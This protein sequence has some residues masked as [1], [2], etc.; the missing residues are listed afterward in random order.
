MKK[1]IFVLIALCGILALSGCQKSQTP[2]SQTS[3][4]E[5]DIELGSN[6]TKPQATQ[7][8]APVETPATDGA[9]PEE[10]SPSVAPDA[11]LPE[12]TPIPVTEEALVFEPSKKEDFPAWFDYENLAPKDALLRDTEEDFQ[13][14]GYLSNIA[15]LESTSKLD[16][17]FKFYQTA[18]KTLGLEVVEEK[19]VNSFYL[20]A[21]KDDKIVFSV[22]AEALISG[23][24]KLVITIT[25]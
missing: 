10:V 23:N 9:Q 17:L 2:I 16:D 22:S 11:P 3:T 20:T 19:L 25:K 6:T 5:P 13:V 1:R 12:E 24:A 14:D 15:V 4:D 21:L 7:G 18:A 8:E